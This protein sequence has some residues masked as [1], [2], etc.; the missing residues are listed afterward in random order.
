MPE[1]DLYKLFQVQPTADLEIIQAAYRRLMLRYHPDRNP[2]P[3]APEMAQRLNRAYEVLSDPSR[4]AEYDREFSSRVGEGSRQAEGSAS[5]NREGGT[6]T[7]NRG[8]L[9]LWAW[10]TAIGA[11]LA[12]AAGMIAAGAGESLNFLDWFSSDQ[13]TVNAPVL[14]PIDTTRVSPIEPAKTIEILV[15]TREAPSP[16]PQ[17]PSRPTTGPSESPLNERDIFILEAAGKITPVT[18]VVLL[19]LVQTGREATLD[20]PG[21]VTL[22]GITPTEDVCLYVDCV[23]GTIPWD[24]GEGISFMVTVEPISPLVDQ[25]YVVWLADLEGNNLHVE[26]VRWS[27]E[28]IEQVPDGEQKPGAVFEGNSG[29]V[30]SVSLF[31]PFDSITVPAFIN[32]YNEVFLAGLEMYENEV[33]I[34]CDLSIGPDGTLQVGNQECLQK[35]FPPY[36][37]DTAQALAV[38][39]RHYKIGLLL[40]SEFNASGFDKSG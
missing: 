11:V 3:E 34:E 28:Q 30:K 16:T 25:N 22:T 18:A 37:L 29:R 40:E 8:R 35:T 38:L 39:E 6:A 1:V 27:I 19:K 31:V 14:E 26:L 17:L 32:D 4:R 5:Y 36:R 15:A 21:S 23:D 2:G 33:I 13:G 9:R 20:L 7:Q 12:I 24:P 10:L